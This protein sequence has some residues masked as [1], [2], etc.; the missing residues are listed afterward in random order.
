MDG[1]SGGSALPFRRT[2]PYSSSPNHMATIFTRD[3][4]P[5]AET[6]KFMPQTTQ[7]NVRPDPNAK[8]RRKAIERASPSMN[9]SFARI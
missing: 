6:R 5:N 9:S 1:C 2:Y 8:S 4:Q 3:P 7:K